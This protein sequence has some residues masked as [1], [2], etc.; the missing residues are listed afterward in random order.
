[1]KNGDKKKAWIKLNMLQSRG[2]I[3]CNRLLDIHKCPEKVLR[4][5]RRELKRIDGLSA[6]AIDRFIS[7]RQIIDI[8]S[9]INKISKHDLSVVT[10]QD[11]GYPEILRHIYSP[12]LALYVRGHVDRLNTFAIAI[13]GTR[14][15]SIYGKE[16]AAQLGY[17]LAISG[18]TVISG[19]ARGIDTCAH[20]GVLRARGVTIAVLGCGLDIV[21][22]PENYELMNEI[23]SNG[24]V[25]SEFP[26][27]TRPLKHNFPLR[28]RIISGLSRGVVVVEAAEKSGALI[29][30]SF[31]LD[32]GRE[33]FSVPGR[34]GQAQSKGTLRLIKDGA[35]LV[36]NAD[37]ILDEFNPDILPERGM[38]PGERKKNGALP[39]NERQRSIIN[40]LKDDARH[41]DD[42]ISD[43][44]I[45][46]AEA[47]KLLLELQLRGIVKE[48][49]G[50]RFILVGTYT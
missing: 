45:G 25:V 27:G 11:K 14:K 36:E 49:P 19:L 16:N 6:E 35:K 1:M 42:I 7:Q 28:N 10:R 39:I 50:K 2:V 24:A 26:M 5:E 12:P 17:G 41:I 34:V 48:I 47:S 20:Q 21:Y 9:E 22:P 23:T 29:T 43:A 44:E 4:L 8:D 3:S 30:A 31:A 37:D 46:L 18:V 33:V 13:V 38:P 40:A 15:A 32:E